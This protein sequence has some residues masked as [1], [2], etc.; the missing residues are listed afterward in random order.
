MA[1]LELVDRMATPKSRTGPTGAMKEADGYIIEVQKSGKTG[2]LAPDTS[3]DSEGNPKE[4]IRSLKTR[5]WQACKRVNEA[6]GSKFEVRSWDDGTFV[7][8]NVGTES[9]PT[10]AAP[11]AKVVDKADR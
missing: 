7:Y 10:A 6:T 2:K 5:L 4:T 11:S 9:A 8:F 1:G 3:R